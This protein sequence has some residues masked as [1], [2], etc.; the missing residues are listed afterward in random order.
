MLIFKHEEF[1]RLFLPSFISFVLIVA[2]FSLLA[3]IKADTTGSVTATVTAQNLALTVADGVV[4]YGTVGVGNSKAT[5][6]GGGELADSQDA[7]NTGN[8]E[9]KFNIKG[10]TSPNWGIGPTA[11]DEEYAHKFCTSNCD[12]SPSWSALTTS[13]ATLV[14]TIGVG[15]TQNFDLILYTPLTTANYTEQSVNVTVQVTTP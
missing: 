3:Q 5:T 10:S 7:V 4:T 14:G 6:T 8:I 15:V 13:Y 2:G 11:G 9:S 12:S 1:R